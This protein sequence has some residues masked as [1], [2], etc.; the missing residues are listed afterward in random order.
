MKK[1]EIYYKKLL[2]VKYILVIQINL[3]IDL[4]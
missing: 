3:Q 1:K 2:I 4:N